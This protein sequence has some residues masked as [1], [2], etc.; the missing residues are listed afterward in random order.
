MVHWCCY[1]WCRRG[2]I[3]GMPQL[4]CHES[5]CGRR[6]DKTRYQEPMQLLYFFVI[7]LMLLVEWQESYPTLIFTQPQIRRHGAT[8]AVRKVY[9]YRTS[10]NCCGRLSSCGQVLIISAA[11][12]SWWRWLSGR[13]SVFGR[14]S[15]PVLRPTCSWRVTTH[16]GKPSAA[17]QPTRST[18]PFILSGSINE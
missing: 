2:G 18:Q 4:F 3:D 14:R 6:K 11:E 17:G 9:N 16:V 12:L 7:A 5:S 13:T 10:N 1:D 15:F 8:G